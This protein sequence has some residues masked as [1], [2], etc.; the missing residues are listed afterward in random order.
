MNLPIKIDKQQIAA[1]CQKHYIIKLA[2][3]GSVLT[4][5]FG[6]DSDVDVL[7]EYDP[8]HVPSLFAVARMERELSEILGRKADMRTSL[9]LSRYFREEVVQH[10]VVQYVA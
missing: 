5:R 2:L 3:F 10:A 6:P 7:F 4:D 9:D 1:F 8:D